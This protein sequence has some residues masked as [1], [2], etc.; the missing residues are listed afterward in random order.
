MTY[1][2]ILDRLDHYHVF[3]LYSDTLP[4]GNTALALLLAAVM[5]AGMAV[6]MLAWSELFA[7]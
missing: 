5:T 3:V 6:S 4:F 7:F 2:K 1:S